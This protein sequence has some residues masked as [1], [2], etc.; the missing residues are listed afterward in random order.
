MT[1]DKGAKGAGEF[2]SFWTVCM[3]DNIYF[4]QEFYRER[5]DE[6]LLWSMQFAKS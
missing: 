3:R 1:K 6:T 5:E 2:L 4:V